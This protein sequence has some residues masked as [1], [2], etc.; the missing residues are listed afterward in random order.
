[1]DTCS[2]IDI[3]PFDDFAR[4]VDPSVY[5][6][7]PD[8]WLIGITDVVNS[9]NT[10]I[11]GGYRAVNM[12]GAA[13]ISAAINA[14]D[15][16]PFPFVFGGDGA[17]FAIPPEDGDTA[18]ELLAA[19]ASWVRRS[20]DLELRVGMVPIRTV[21]ENGYDVR[22]AR[23]AASKSAVYAMFSGGGVEWAERMLK[24]G[25]FGLA[26]AA[27]DA[28]PDLTGLSCQWGPVASDHG[29]ILSMIVKPRHDAEQPSFAVLIQEILA[30]L[31]RSGRS[32]PLPEDGPEIVWPGDRLMFQVLAEGGPK[33]YASWAF[34][35][36]TIKAL[37]AWVLFKTNWTLI[38]FEPGRY[39][40]R[41]V[42]NTD[43]RKYDDGLM[44]TVDCTTEAAA[45]I[46]SRL[47]EAQASGIADFGLHRQETALM[48]CIVPSVFND[49][50]LH[51]LDGGGGGYAQAARK[52][53]QAVSDGKTTADG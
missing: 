19:T 3:E 51:F 32:N 25:H 34:A 6:S 12:A 26:A 30:I 42:R 8:D 18:S 4:I 48:T 46:Q 28:M 37:L 53:K 5:R 33:R 21:R 2:Y 40:Q 20:L 38:G 16:K 29:I 14:F 15:G 9:T 35:R 36:S 49:D 11:A 52:L 24:S 47:E 41:M 45:T 1:M 44:M 31:G 39:R 22:V 13:T 50:H 27:P 17:C 10:L 7:L 23:Y 43:Y